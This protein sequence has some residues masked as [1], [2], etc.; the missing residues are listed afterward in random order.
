MFNKTDALSQALGRQIAAE[1]LYRT[2][3][4]LANSDIGCSNR[5]TDD[6]EGGRAGAEA[7]VQQESVK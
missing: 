4:P 3:S 7:N 1:R 2:L 5:Q 6:H